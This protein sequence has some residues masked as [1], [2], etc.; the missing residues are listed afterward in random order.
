[1]DQ[2]LYR[3]HGGHYAPPPPSRGFTT[4][5]KARVQSLNSLKKLRRI[6]LNECALKLPTDGSQDNL[7]RCFKD[8]QSCEAG[9]KMLREQIAVIKDL[10]FSCNKN[11]LHEITDFEEANDP[12]NLID[13]DLKT[14]KN[15]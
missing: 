8:K 10:A 11:T 6:H 3:G 14:D 13:S 5:K 9:A 4:A 15:L 7:I 2:K 12:C 1:M